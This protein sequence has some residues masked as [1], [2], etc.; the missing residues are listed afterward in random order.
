MRNSK[1]G[2]KALVLGIMVILGAMALA[3]GAQAQETHVEKLHVETIENTHIALLHTAT[4]I[5]HAE[6]LT[7]EANH[8]ASGGTLNPSP[9]AEPKTNSPGTFLISLAPVPAGL[10]A[11]VVATQ[12]GIGSILVAGRSLE[13]R[14]AKLELIGAKINTTDDASGEVKFTG[15][16]SFDHKTLTELTTCLLKELE[17]I[18]ATALVLPILHNGEPFLL[19]EPQVAGTPFTIVKYKAGI[20]CVLPLENPVTGSVSALVELL[21]AVRQLILFSTGIQLLTG[22]KLAFGGFP[23]YITALDKFELSGPHAGQK[24]GIH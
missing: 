4:L 17:T 5:T 18:K 14:C 1:H 16:K 15:C 23:S 19:F 8:N 7:K 21:D 13:I 12:I 11:T 2:L 22:D 20:G 24:L 10:N 9:L 3:A 6:L